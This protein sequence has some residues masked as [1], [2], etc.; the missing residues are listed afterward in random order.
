M[1]YALY[2]GC[3]IQNEQ[4]GC[5]ISTRQTFPRLGV[6]LVDMVGTSCCGLPAFSSLSTLGWFY[7]STRNIAIA[8]R[9]GLDV[10]AL[11][12]GCYESLVQTKHNLD[13]D[14]NLQEIINDR[15]S[16]EGLEY[17]GTARIVHPIS[18]LHDVIGVDAIEEKVE[19]PLKG[20]KFASHPGCHA[21]RPSALGMPDHPE[22]PEK[23]DALIAA[24][25]AET[26]DY[27]EKVDCCGSMLASAAAST[28]LTIA[29]EKLK[30]VEGYGFDGLVTTCPFCFQMFDGRQE[31]I[32]DMIDFLLDNEPDEVELPVFYYTQLLGLAMGMKP[33]RLG[34][35]LNKS[36]VDRVL[37]K[38]EEG[39]DK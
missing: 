35:Q 8:E 29:A 2:L 22:H 16:K 25:G 7:L 13:E 14:P 17:T 6:E 3:T 19:K 30:A 27:P 32:N 39:S 36:P 15:L 1:K 18:L 37:V 10:L 12:N 5:E 28:T 38:I 4:Y 31:E 23:M 33:D 26:M 34:L 9:K 24:L 20:F 21:I 11:C